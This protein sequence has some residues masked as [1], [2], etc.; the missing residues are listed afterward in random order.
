MFFP[1]NY[2]AVGVT[3]Q[4]HF[5]EWHLER[6]GKHKKYFPHLLSFLLS[7]GLFLDCCLWFLLQLCCKDRF[8]YAIFKHSLQITHSPLGLVQIP[9]C[10]LAALKLIL[11][12]PQGVVAKPGK[13]QKGTSRLHLA[14]PLLTCRSRG[15]SRPKT[16]W[17]LKKIGQNHRRCP[18]CLFLAEQDYQQKKNKN[19]CCVLM[20]SVEC[21]LL[22]KWIF[23]ICSSFIR[24]STKSRAA[25]EQ[26]LCSPEAALSSPEDKSPTL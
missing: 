19:P 21:L 23:F 7:L 12:M 10:P 26:Q 16:L 8:S 25:V 14:S 17:R 4:G 1:S 22:T 2:K 5:R 3:I 15:T 24:D 11:F 9:L 18:Y 20:Q 6:M 13:R